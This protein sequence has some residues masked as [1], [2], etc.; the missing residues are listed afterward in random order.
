M[1]E[2]F[3]GFGRAILAFILILAGIFS[4]LIGVAAVVGMVRLI[5]WLAFV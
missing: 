1:K 2:F 5:Q 3:D 4:L